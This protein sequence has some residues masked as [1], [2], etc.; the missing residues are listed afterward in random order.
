M[1]SFSW[2]ISAAVMLAATAGV[3]LWAQVQ[4]ADPVFGASTINVVAPTLVKDR[5]GNFMNGLDVRDF[6]V[7]DNGKVQDVKIDQAYVPISLVLVIQRSASTEQVLPTVQK[8]GSMLEPLVIGEHG[9][10]AIVTFDH[11]VETIQD[12]TNDTDKFKKALATLRPT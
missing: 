7:R 3:A 1:N 9:E 8:I 6:V 5:D 2:R 11:R 12:F 4:P 10:A